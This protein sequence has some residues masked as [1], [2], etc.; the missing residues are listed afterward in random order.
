MKYVRK[1]NCD[2]SLIDNEWIILNP[3]TYTITTLNSVGGYCWEQLTDPLS[4]EEL[5]KRINKNFS[6]PIEPIHAEV[7][8]FMLKM[9]EYDLIQHAG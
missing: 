1:K 9:M 3:E 6:I 5:V 7:E 4:V 2:I 8:Q